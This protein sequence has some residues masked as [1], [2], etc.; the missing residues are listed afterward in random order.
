MINRNRCWLILSHC[1]NIDGIAAAL[2]ID[3]RLPYLK[4][5][6]ITPIMLTGPCAALFKD[7]IHI[8]V[9]SIAPSGIR[10]EGRYL[11]RKKIPNRFWFK[12]IETLCML[13]LFPLYLLEKLIIDIDSQWSWFF[14]AALRGTHL[15][16]KYQ[17]ELIYSTGGATSAHLAA[18]IIAFLRG[19]PWIAEFQDPL[20]YEEWKKSTRSKKVY[21]FI[22]R[23]ICGKASAVI[24]LTGCA[25]DRA[26]GRTRPAKKGWVVYPGASLEP[27][28]QAVYTRSEICRFSHFGSLG[29]SRNLNMF[30]KALQL[31]FVEMPELNQVIRLDIYGSYDRQIHKEIKNFPYPNVIRDFGRVPHME[32]LVA[33]KQS[34]VL[35]L[36]Q[37]TE[38][39]SVETIPA[40][41]YE[42][43]NT[44]RPILGLVYNNPELQKMLEAQGHLA[45][46]ADRAEEVKRGISFYIDSWRRGGLL[47]P[48][49]RSPYTIGAAV[50]T[51]VENVDVMLNQRR[52]RSAQGQC[53][54]PQL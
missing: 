19:I 45:V 3:N 5:R 10:F 16:K 43:L 37:N 54:N 2:H 24:F 32:T 27:L 21:K 15:T 26:S 34:D 33:M 40:K 31:L 44:G 23:L 20:I 41:T 35:L 14:L 18:A 13:P 1:S 17:P 52:E 47:L 53:H 42:Y 39:F 51:I 6:G 8:R 46:D 38:D 9:P 12:V 4:N 49:S 30:L 22:E 48:A 11:L 50:D 29:G 36:I 7:I 28:P 25:R